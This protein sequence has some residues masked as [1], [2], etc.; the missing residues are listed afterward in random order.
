MT[1][2]F[3]A[4]LTVAVNNETWGHICTVR[5]IRQGPILQLPLPG[6][7]SSVQCVEAVPA[8]PP[9]SWLPLLGLMEGRAEGSMNS[10][11][12]PWTHCRPAQQ[13]R[14]FGGLK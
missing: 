10:F 7:H 1:C 11:T 9:L 2:L 8:R 5:R 12:V 13:W 14:C 4:A 3:V 6:K